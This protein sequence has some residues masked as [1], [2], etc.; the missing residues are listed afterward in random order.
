MAQRRNQYRTV[1]HAIVPLPFLLA[2]LL[3]CFFAWWSSSTAQ[4]EEPQ[5]AFVYSKSLI[6]HDA[7]EQL[8]N[9]CIPVRRDEFERLVSDA[10]LKESPE[11]DESR[12]KLG[13]YRAR[14]EDYA[15]VKGK[16]LLTVESQKDAPMYLR[17]KGGGVPI[18][19]PKWRRNT[20]A[21]LGH[22]RSGNLI[23]VVPPNKKGDTRTLRFDWSLSGE[24]RSPAE[25]S[26]RLRLLPA[27]NNRVSLW[28]PKALRLTT[29]RGH[30]RPN[31][32]NASHNW[33]IELGSVSETEITIFSPELMRA[34]SPMLV[35]E[36]NTSFDITPQ[37]VRGK[38]T[39]DL[40]AISNSKQKLSFT[41]TPGV[42]IDSLVVNGKAARIQP[43][44]KKRKDNLQLFQVELDQPLPAGNHEI[45]CKFAADAKLD[46]TLTLP[47]VRPRG[48]IWQS[49]RATVNVE[50]PL[51]VEELKLLNA[52][53]T[54]ASITGNGRPT[55][56]MTFEFHGP[57]SNIEI[58]PN[59]WSSKSR[60]PRL[61]RE[62][63]SLVTL[64][65]PKTTS[66]L[67]NRI[68]NL[69]GE[70]FTLTAEVLN[71]W[72]I[73][74][75]EVRPEGLLEVWSVDPIQ[76]LEKEKSAN[77]DHPSRRLLEIRLVRPISK[78]SEVWVQ[79]EATR[80]RQ[81]LG[82]QLETSDLRVLEFSNLTTDRS[83]RAVRAFGSRSLRV[84]GALD[85]TPLSHQQLS[86]EEQLL[87]NA[88]R[89][90]YI[91]DHNEGAET[92]RFAALGGQPAWQANIETHSSIFEE[93]VR[94]RVIVE[95]LP[96]VA[97][98]EEI[99]V[100]ISPRRDEN[101]TWHLQTDAGEKM[102]LVATELEEFSLDS[103]Q[104]DREIQAWKI[105]IPALEPTPIRIVGVREYAREDLSELTLCEAITPET[106][107]L[108]S[109]SL[110]YASTEIAATSH[111]QTVREILPF[112]AKN[113][114]QV[115]TSFLVN[116]S[117][118]GAGPN[119]VS[120]IEPP[121]KTWISDATT[122][123]RFDRTN[124]W[125][126]ETRWQV[127]NHGNRYLTFQLGR[128]HELRRV[129]INERAIIGIGPDLDG[130]V[131]V[132]MPSDLRK[133]ELAF[134]Y[135][136][137]GSPFR[138]RQTVNF[139]SPTPSCH[140]A[141]HRW[142]IVMS[143]DLAP[144][145]PTRFGVG[146]VERLFGF[147]AKNPRISGK[148][149]LSQQL[150]FGDLSA[151]Y[152]AIS[153]YRVPTARVI[154]WLAFLGLLALRWETSTRWR[155]IICSA[156]G[157]M[158]MICFPP[159]LGFFRGIF[160]GVIA[161]W[162]R[163]QIPATRETQ[164]VWNWQALL[165]RPSATGSLAIFL[166]LAVSDTSNSQIH[167]Q[168]EKASPIHYRVFFP[169]DAE[170]EP[171]GKYVYVPQ[172]MYDSL[173]LLAE[174][175]RPATDLWLLNSAIY[176][177]Q[178]S[179]KIRPL[180]D[181][182]NESTRYSIN[183]LSVNFTL[184]TF[185][186][187]V[188]VSLPLG[189]PL[190][191]ISSEARL[192]GESINW[193]KVGGEMQFMVEQAGS[194]KLV[195]EIRIPQVDDLST[196][197]VR[198][199][200]LPIIPLANCQ[201]EILTPGAS[202]GTRVKSSIGHISST[203][204]RRILQA[205]LGPVD[206]I[207][208][209]WNPVAPKAENRNFT[210]QKLGWL[211]VRPGVAIYEV[212]FRSRTGTPGDYLLNQ[213]KISV[214]D[215]LR[216]FPSSQQSCD[217]EVVNLDD[218]FHDIVVRRRANDGRDNLRVR[219]LME[220]KHNPSRTEWQIPAIR[221]SG[222]E[223]DNEWLSVSTSPGLS[224]EQTRS[225]SF[226][227][228]LPSQFL[229]AWPNPPNGAKPS[230]AVARKEEDATWNVRTL[231]KRSRGICNSDLRLHFAR[232]ATKI[233]FS[234]EISTIE[235]GFF[236]HV[237]QGPPEL[238]TSNVRVLSSSKDNN[239]EWFQLADGTIHVFL[240]EQV[241]GRHTILVN[242]TIPSR[243]GS[244]M[245]IPSFA[246]SD[247]PTGDSHIRLFRRPDVILGI[248]PPE[249]ATR[250]EPEELVIEQPMPSIPVAAFKILANESSGEFDFAKGSV[251]V[252]ENNPTLTGNCLTQMFLRS[253]ADAWI[254]TYRLKAD[255][256]N[257]I[258]DVL[259]FEIPETW[260][261]DPNIT[262]DLPMI[263]KS[264]PDGR[265]RLIVSPTKSQT[266]NSIDLE[267]ESPVQTSEA[268]ELPR[269][270]LLGHEDV[271]RYV[272]LP[273]RVANAER[274]WE[275]ARLTRVALPDEIRP[276][277]NRILGTTTYRAHSE[278]SATL[279]QPEEQKTPV[280]VLTDVHLRANQNGFSGRVKLFVDPMGK[281]VAKISIP[282]N[283]TLTAILLDGR[284]AQIRKDLTKRTCEFDFGPKR[285][286]QHVE[287]LFHQDGAPSTTFEVP[288]LLDAIYQRNIWSLA[289][290]SD[291]NWVAGPGTLQTTWAEDAKKR[292]TNALRTMRRPIEA[293]WPYS[294]KEIRWWFEPW[295]ERV[296]QLANQESSIGGPES[297]YLSY[298]YGEIADIER[299]LRIVKTK[300]SPK[301]KTDGQEPEKTATR[302]QEPINIMPNRRRPH[303]LL[304]TLQGKMNYPTSKRVQNFCTPYSATK[305]RLKANRAWTNHF[306]P[307]YAML[308]AFFASLIC[309]YRS[310]FAE[311]LQG[312]AIRWPQFVLLLIGVVWLLLLKFAWVGLALMALACWLAL[313]GGVA[314]QG[315]QA[316]IV[317]DS[318]TKL[319]PEADLSR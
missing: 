212:C 178:F 311:E 150:E 187:N 74:S 112:D 192:N 271:D 28:L 90:D 314:V 30:L 235:G 70:T 105:A 169:I 247:I 299:Q 222:Q 268:T 236:H 232:E 181:S 103:L 289:S 42:R 33:I 45:V 85:M 38:S 264:L 129:R 194:H 213:L 313:S 54:D 185:Q 231:P 273:N 286:P 170:G 166:L 252:K 269:I 272:V 206:R 158:L 100:A 93:S 179:S 117:N 157:G 120:F 216:P 189:I 282:E 109:K 146:F 132:P 101:V 294:T 67:V 91:F 204:D 303:P 95:C 63:G 208:V 291:K 76:P 138:F 253:D 295:K 296:I 238:V 15:L 174:S 14:F 275:T 88:R 79:M 225:P 304:E 318:P 37:A 220:A 92:L 139:Q 203:E 228:I 34:S 68:E 205:Q 83:L 87:L 200:E 106:T 309:A 52:T 248:T 260:G 317:R 172:E 255:V 25:V 175:K 242:G 159:Y 136:E 245:S 297:A 71:G 122:T 57:D 287:I 140:E 7:V 190:E 40:N 199:F 211:N 316:L 202:L 96:E 186:A 218:G 251:I 210:V 11:P 124:T 277:S 278:Y 152:G 23:A 243:I 64:G 9:N 250:I 307:R 283:V 17:A 39:F 227:T 312:F 66:S 22:G 10:T 145:F 137:R 258:L 99:V 18:G 94:D 281:N 155:V 65:G 59:S 263:V 84:T 261:S 27:L 6:P 69:A 300:E 197:P 239:A 131:R 298:V 306:S 72:K 110:I 188:T 167:D 196:K 266:A 244:K 246:L 154:G 102:P 26:F 163:Q 3:A 177:G 114:G 279:L 24:K 223:F 305:L 127:E 315:Y 147:L 221:V 193:E 2:T 162:L 141:G 119:S 98:P 180:A 182:E 319:M 133:L 241:A 293:T 20:P 270:E 13:I 173:V 310:Q 276:S 201:L 198:G 257:G 217:V 240:H 115:L 224:V 280:I 226:E 195:F 128:Q 302:Q 107:E 113:G 149:S 44:P 125:L 267:I 32:T 19:N 104:L 56:S 134:S 46:T 111:V 29:S 256:K 274:K 262:P 82:D 121:A 50:H 36:D 290:D 176:R 12:I 144:Y 89:G 118:F 55:R 4:G 207:Q 16:A 130:I 97:N 292:T 237:V 171:S 215:R 183:K 51:N 75:L 285:L 58:R 108:R 8:D 1:F 265:T 5:P 148:K 126:H 153:I 249:N 43:L 35:Y 135:S 123:S 31:K 156:V 151:G 230:F 73:E 49:G 61:R 86:P 168:I 284:L 48:M 165:Y 78:G 301:S 233:E 81:K 77:D 116:K 234:S 60:Q 308:L 229:R 53:Q 142:H 219:F 80:E 161:N 184:T 160:W 47:R 259:H 209:Q 288:Q 214:D 254:A 62:A 41:Q 164:Q 21:T 191:S 143:G